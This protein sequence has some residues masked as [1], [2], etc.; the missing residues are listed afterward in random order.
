MRRNALLVSVAALLIAL[1]P[2]PA[3]AHPGW[4][5]D[6]TYHNNAATP[7]ADPF[8]LFDKA[9]GYY[10][11]YSTEGAD[12]GYNFAIYRSPD[13]ATWE[14][15]PGGA[16]LAGQDGDWA[17]DWF[18]APE[19]YHNPATGLYFLFYAGRMNRGVAEHFRYP[20]FEEASKVG[21]AVSQSPAGP[22]RDIA[23]A[24]LDYYPY[25][26]A[27]HDVNL[28]M[29]ATQKKP[30]ATLEEGQTAPLGTY[31]PF[32]DPNVFFD[33]DGRIYLYYSRNA[34]RNW[35]WDTDLGKYIEES[36]IYAVELTGD[37]W[38]DPTGATMP[39]IAPAYRNA[40]LAPSDPP[41]TRKDGFVPILNYGSDK[42]DWENAH[43]DDYANSGG[44]K[45]D[46]RWAEGSTTLRT[47]DTQ[48]NPLYYLTYSA[49]NFENEYYG[50]GYATSHSP[51]GP[52][53]KSRTN[54]VLS[55]D[56]AKGLYSTGHGS[57]VDS[58]DG[59]EH[60]YVHH[61]RPSTESPRAI[62][63]SA[64]YL[65][66]GLSMR[67]STSDEPVPS[68]VGPLTPRTDD[69]VLKTSPGRPVTTT[70]HV[71][72]A[73]GAEF[74][75]ANPLNRVRATLRP[76]SAGTVTV[77][78]NQVTVTPSGRGLALLTVVYQREL[79]G[80]GYRDVANTGPHLSMPVRVAIPVISR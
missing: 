75:L 45:K 59:T 78:G 80:G 25:D 47:V 58:P 6:A 36:N 46:R 33:A 17:H 55:Q 65:G 64:L 21:V 54:P 69:R 23:E 63:T 9:S 12:P 20:D 50:V 40:N 35:V 61:G 67:S 1:V 22:F 77:T 27:Y 66:G 57:V 15:L 71:W 76:A 28:I 31:L 30:P 8:V 19:V 68:G 3:A 26:P 32:I 48:G 10:Y 38:T 74:D 18:W 70:A 2:V 79:A 13:L 49:N 5:T 44:E 72:S 62:Y 16:L 52:W 14:H 42:Q 56:P 60:Y 41:G 4:T 51:L 37:W 11:A 29:D 53:R 34:Y 24:P 7:G 43:V 39:A 73:P